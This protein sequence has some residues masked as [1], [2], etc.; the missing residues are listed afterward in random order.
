[1]KQTPTAARYTSDV[2][3]QRPQSAGVDEHIVMAAFTSDRKYWWMFTDEQAA[4]PVAALFEFREQPVLEH[5][6]RIELDSSQQIDTQS[7][8]LLT[9]RRPVCSGICHFSRAHTKVG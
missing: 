1:M 6:R 3:H 4:E 8:R 5:H 2:N 7:R 9:D